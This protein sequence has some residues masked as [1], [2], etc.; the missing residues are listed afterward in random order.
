MAQGGRV[1]VGVSGSLRSLAALHRAVDET[2]RRGAALTAV[3]AWT[4]AGGEVASRRSPCPSLL[5][6]CESAAAARLQ[7]AFRDAFGGY[8][9][10]LRLRLATVRGEPGHALTEVA[11]RP[12]DLLVVGAGRRGGLPRLFNGRVSRYCVAHARCAVLAVPPSD[13][14]RDLGRTHRVLGELPLRRAA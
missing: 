10:G 4:P 5:T 2:R 9:E 8:P 1:V 7:Q 13:L 6:A 3:L 12:D 11:D 14:M